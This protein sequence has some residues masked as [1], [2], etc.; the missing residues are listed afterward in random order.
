MHA[1]QKQSIALLTVIAVATM[2]GYPQSGSAIV[3]PAHDN[4]GRYPNITSVYNKTLEKSNVLRPGDEIEI[5]GTRLYGIH[6]KTLVHFAR[7]IDDA[8][9]WRPGNIR[10]LATTAKMASP[11][12]ITVI[13]PNVEGET[14]GLLRV[15]NYRVIGNLESS[16]V[17]PVTWELSPAPVSPTVTITLSQDNAVKAPSS[18]ITGGTQGVRTLYLTFNPKGEDVQLRFLKL[19]LADL[20][21][22]DSVSAVQLY[23]ASSTKIIDGAYIE[24]A[25]EATFGNGQT[26]FYTL[27][28]DAPTTF[29]IVTD[30]RGVGT[31]ASTADSGDEI[32]WIL[33]AE[34]ANDLTNS[35]I[36]FGAESSTQ[37]RYDSNKSESQI[38]FGEGSSQQDILGNV[39]HIRRATMKDIVAL[40]LGT[41]TPVDGS[42]APLTNGN[43]VEVFRFQISAAP[44]SDNANSN[45]AIDLTALD[46]SL[47]ASGVT[48]ANAHI[49]RTDAPS[50][51]VMANASSTTSS[52]IVF[53]STGASK[54]SSLSLIPPG[55]NA[56]FAVM[57]DVAGAEQGES[58]HITINSLG[59]QGTEGVTD[60]SAG[61]L[62]WSDNDD[63]ITDDLTSWVSWQGI[64]ITN[65][66]GQTRIFPP[67]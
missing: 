11:Q 58:T 21:A 39:F 64:A 32:K 50:I 36:A 44:N 6:G 38:L 17:Y 47:Y 57:A 33:D 22:A 35:I 13:V 59:S 45:G 25:G 43:N 46:L 2:I 5:T 30:A 1:I 34:I 54:L 42:T 65:V 14:Q 53:D 28:K 40:K 37:L 29:A 41:T 62:A 20:S 4:I 61:D 67:S 18:Q 12:I 52:R 9:P 15:T 8:K 63:I 55:Q 49:Y 48:I 66:V 10:T 31:G 3:K 27:P 23:N 51:I 7:K 26:A 56:I 24:S 16:P 19:N 60:L